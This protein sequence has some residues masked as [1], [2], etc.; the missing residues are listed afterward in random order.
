M[1]CRGD[2]YYF[3]NPFCVGIN[4][5]P[6]T[7]D[8][9][10]HGWKAVRV[11]L[12]DSVTVNQI[13]KM[14]AS[15]Q[16]RVEAELEQLVC[17][18]EREIPLPSPVPDWSQTQFFCAV[19]RTCKE[20]KD[21]GFMAFQ[22]QPSGVSSERLALEVVVE[23]IESAR[24]QARHQTEV[25]EVI[26]DELWKLLTENRQS[27]QHAKTLLRTASRALEFYASESNWLPNAQCNLV[28]G[29]CGQVA[30]KALQQIKSEAEQ[31][32]D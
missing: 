29:D 17:R 13:H 3:P 31:Q 18:L 14:K 28:Q 5:A 6:E 10:A 24:A 20:L 26:R 7:E 22:N 30:A 12:L 23:E 11:L 15:D 25:L 8:V 32:G 4:P 21:D 1:C 2:C 9:L 27:L 19:K 16:K